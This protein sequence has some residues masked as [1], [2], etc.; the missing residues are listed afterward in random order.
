MFSLGSGFLASLIGMR[1]RN[2]VLL[3]GHGPQD[4]DL[5]S[6]QGNGSHV[7]Q[8]EPLVIA[9]GMDLFILRPVF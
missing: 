7:V 4:K 9:T 2:S 3:H 5:E 6:R 1:R 8:P